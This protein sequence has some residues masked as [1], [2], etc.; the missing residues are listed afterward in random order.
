MPD[1]EMI[2]I[3]WSKLRMFD[4]CPAKPGLMRAHKGPAS[5][6]RNYFPGTVADRLMG[7]WLSLDP[8][9]PGWMAAH[10]DEF[11]VSEEIT[12]R[13]TGDGVVRW[14]SAGD[15]AEVREFVHE[16]VVRLEE[17][18]NVYCLPFDWEP[19]WRFR[20][21]VS[22]DGTDV[23]LTGETDLLV[24]EPGE[25]GRIALWDLKATKNNAYFQKVLGQ[26]AFYFI[27]IA[28]SR[29]TRFGPH[30]LGRWPVSGGLIQPMCDQRVL[31]VEVGDQAIREIMGRIENVTR[32]IRAGRTDPKPGSYCQWCE[33]RHACPVFK[34]EGGRG[35]VSIPV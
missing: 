8:P 30:Q 13:E 12:A 29:G 5:D 21:P 3:S 2:S 4:E 27:A 28:A 24:F 25:A 31:P 6:I 19:H 11:L 10:V 35:R 33:V 16:V 32:A 15:K 20:V 18:L 26:I 34:I 22:I 23:L 17:I 9:P 14:K 7:A 1:T